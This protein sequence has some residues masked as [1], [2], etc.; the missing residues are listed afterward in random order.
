MPSLKSTASKK[1][2]E[3]NPDGVPINVVWD[4]LVVGASVFIPA[5]NVRK[6]AI[7]MR[8]ASLRRQMGLKGVERIEA[9]KLGMRFWRVL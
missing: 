8:N 5:V 2:S 3:I 1:S 9:G 6:L 7:Q 4:E